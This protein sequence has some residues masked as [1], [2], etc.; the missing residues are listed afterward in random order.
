MFQFVLLDLIVL[1]S[2]HALN[3]ILAVQMATSAIH[4]KDMRVKVKW[5]FNLQCTKKEMLL[6]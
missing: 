3:T 4:T 6:M 2:I 1:S 5:T